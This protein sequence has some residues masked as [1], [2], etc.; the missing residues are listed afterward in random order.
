VNLFLQFNSAFGA[1]YGPL[2]GIIA[3]AFW[4]Y[5]SA[6]ALLA[7]AALSAQ[8]E[9]VRAGVTTP[10]SARKVVESEPWQT[11]GAGRRAGLQA[12]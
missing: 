10:Q 1:T 5:F 12:S 8:L 9:A 2:A 4:A 11:A 6:V 3:L 7:G